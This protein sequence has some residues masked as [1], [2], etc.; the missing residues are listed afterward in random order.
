MLNFPKMN[1]GSAGENSGTAPAE[2]KDSATESA[3]PSEIRD[4]AERLANELNEYLV[5]G[6]QK[7][8]AGDSPP[9]SDEAVADLQLKTARKL[10]EVRSGMLV[11]L[12]LDE[13]CWPLS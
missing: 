13:C 3:E 5:K 8:F 7:S 12:S 10:R 11:V 6:A 4:G 1:F 9:L 2:G